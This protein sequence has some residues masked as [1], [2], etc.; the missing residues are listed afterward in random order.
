MK[1]SILKNISYNFI[2]KIISYLFSFLELL[3]V[4]RVLQP[5]AFG[6]TSF[7]SSYAGYF[8]LLANL[9]MPVYAMRACAEKG[10]DRK[11]LSRTFHEL[12]SINVVMSAASGAVFAGT[13]LLFPRLRENGVLLAIYGS[14]IL[15][16]MIG[17]EWL[18]RGLEKFR[19][20]A[21]SS[22]VCK[23]VSFI[24]ILMFVRSAQQ[25]WLYALFSVLTAYGSSV[26]CFLALHRYVD[27]SFRIH[28]NKNHFKPLFVFFMMSC[29]VSV[30]SSLDL[31]M[32]GFMK[33]EYETGLY[34]I[35]AKGKSV[36]AMTGGLVWN[37][38]LPLA[39]KLWKA[40]DRN[41]FESIAAK[42]LVIVSAIQ[43]AVAFICIIFAEELI[44]FAG[45]EAYLGSVPAFQIL[46]LS[47]IPIGASNILGGQVLIPAGKERRLL[48]AEIAGAVFNFIANMILIP[49]LSILGAALTTVIS[50]VIVWLLCIY[51]IKKDLNMD[52]GIA[53]IR[54]ATGKFIRT[55]RLIRIRARS[56]HKGTALPYYCPCCN[57][58]L[59]QFVNGGYENRPDIY[60]T[61]RYQEIDQNVIC[62][63][64]GSLPRHR[65]LVSWM[66]GNQEWVAGKSILHFA[67]E[68]SVRMWFDRYHIDYTTADL[69]HSADLKINI[70]DTG[71]EDGSYDII[72]C[73]HVLEHVS[74]YKKALSEMYRIIRPG[75]RMI[76]SFPVD[77]SFRTVYEDHTISSEE[78]RVRHFG[79]N[80]HLRIFGNDSA[81]LLASFGF[82]VTEI[83]GTGC[84]TKIKPV[85]GPA[86]YDDNVLWCL[87]KK[88]ALP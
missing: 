59:K 65:I 77:R 31:I 1:R 75:G 56:R 48:S 69:Y 74:D 17:C 73:N 50:E 43:T 28:I 88:T 67:Q 3:Y 84:D 24:C 58:Y 18:F 38:I 15:F 80:D 16:Q 46:L 70:E 78:E 79:Q 19:F 57:T 27:F 41:H 49:Y 45:G 35:A 60:N 82:Q 51:Y 86:D 30:Y 25:V 53:I 8:V 54:K 87:T 42:S 13:V 26:A 72:I 85:V 20:L 61:A 81:E 64:C 10:D 63:V 66:N 4:T 2:I 83:T 6:R 29:A 34:S 37:A 5:E 44:V 22:L 52:F 23:A 62:P 33:T 21:V 68:K 36:L 14:T 11:E 39:T 7:A 71:L 47:L 32:L 55:Y 12:W 76:I 40:G 9:G